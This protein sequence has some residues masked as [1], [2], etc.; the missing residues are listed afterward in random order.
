MAVALRYFTDYGKP[1]RKSIRTFWPPVII[2]GGVG[3]MSEWI[4]CHT[5]DPTTYIL[6]TSRRSAVSEILVWMAKKSA[7]KQNDERP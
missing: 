7:A 3:E 5:Y 1:G 6:V 4:L 2:R